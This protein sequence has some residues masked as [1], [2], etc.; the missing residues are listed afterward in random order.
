[1]A[2]GASTPGLC[3]LPCASTAC[4]NRIAA[5]KVASLVSSVHATIARGRWSK[6]RRRVHSVRI[7]A[8]VVKRARGDRGPYELK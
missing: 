4:A 6:T 8:V 3:M 5:S 1:M 7:V 2:L